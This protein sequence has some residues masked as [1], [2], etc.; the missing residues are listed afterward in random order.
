MTLFLLDMFFLMDDLETPFQQNF[1]REI[2]D[3]YKVTRTPPVL[4]VGF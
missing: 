3:V 4:F 2:D 1:L